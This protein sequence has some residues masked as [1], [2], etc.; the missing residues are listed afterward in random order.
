M[1]KGSTVK[2]VIVA[3]DNRSGVCRQGLAFVLVG[4]NSHR[5]EKNWDRNARRR[6][7]T[8]R[9][10]PRRPLPPA[11]RQYQ[12]LCDLRLQTKETPNVIAQTANHGA[13]A[14]FSALG[15]RDTASAQ[16]MS[17]DAGMQYDQAQPQEGISPMPPGGIKDGHAKKLS[18]CNFTVCRCRTAIHTLRRESRLRGPS[19]I[20]PYRRRYD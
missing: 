20:R 19:Q 2:G 3:S 15:A 1:A 14:I 11:G 13:L 16:M 7:R 17:P 6:D 5:N 4:T 10:H 9:H 8:N 18:A 12:R